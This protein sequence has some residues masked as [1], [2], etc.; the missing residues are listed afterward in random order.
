MALE[1]L[2]KPQIE[3]QPP[4]ESTDV[5]LESR[6]AAPLDRLAAVIADFVLISPIAAFIMSPFRRIA[7]EAMLQGRDDAWMISTAVSIGLS[8]LVVILYQTIFLVKWRATPGKR[9]FGLTVET[10][11]STEGSPIRPQAAFMRACALCFELLLL[12]L[13]LIGV[14]G[15]DRRRPLHDRL[16][17][18]IVL[19]KRRSKVGVPGLSEKSLASGLV[20]AFFMS[21]LIVVTFKVGQLRG[22]N[23]SAAALD[24]E[25]AA[26]CEN[27]AR[28]DQNWV[29]ALGEKKPSRISI[30]LTLF[31]A[32]AIDESCLKLEAD[33]TLWEKASESSVTSHAV[34]P[35]KS[36]SSR[37]TI[38]TKLA[39]RENRPTPVARSR[40]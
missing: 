11:W 29:P 18:T 27:V 23:T 20:G 8:V 34:S 4:S 22:F 37:K 28:A 30:A 6:L 38:L 21:L 36:T 19:S 17:D 26:L 24:G 5:S 40:S 13:P 16:A 12:G 25:S 10:L 35:K 9:L 1:D 33:A 2:P 15:N 7:S 31:E 32:D 3:N 14:I 39:T